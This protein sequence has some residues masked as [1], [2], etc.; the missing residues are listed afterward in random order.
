[1]TYQNI[2]SVEGLGIKQLWQT[3][4]GAVVALSTTINVVAST[5]AAVADATGTV[6]VASLAVPE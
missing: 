3:T 4:T 5:A 2:T 6:I 1:M